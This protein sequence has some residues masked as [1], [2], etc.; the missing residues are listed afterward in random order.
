MEETVSLVKRLKRQE[1]KLW[2]ELRRV[3]A[4]KLRRK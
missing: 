4:A 1:E 2:R 3:L